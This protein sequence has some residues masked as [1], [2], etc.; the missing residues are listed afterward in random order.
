MRIKYNYEDE[1]HIE[2]ALLKFNN[3]MSGI[4]QTIEDVDMGYQNI[5]IDRI[6]KW[7]SNILEKYK[8]QVNSK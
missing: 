3:S 2:N 7:D 8:K 5:L 1:E 4:N 6:I